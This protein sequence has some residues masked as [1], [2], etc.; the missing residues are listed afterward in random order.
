MTQKDKGFDGFD[1]GKSGFWSDPRVIINYD[2]N[3]YH[4]H[5]DAKRGFDAI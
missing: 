5:T 4:N 3:S 1:G 2:K